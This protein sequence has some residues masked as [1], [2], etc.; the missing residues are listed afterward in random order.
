MFNTFGNN[1]RIKRTPVTE[2]KGL[3]DKVGE[4]YGQTTPSMMDFEIIGNLKEDFAL[5]VYFEDLQESFWFAEELIEHLDNGQGT[6]ITLNGINK[7]WTKVENGN[8]IESDTSPLNSE[9]T[10]VQNQIQNNK[11]WWMFWKQ[12]I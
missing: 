6:K 4:I 7:K 5:N 10:S 2:A 3:A 8:W 1:V 9:N 12:N 11:K